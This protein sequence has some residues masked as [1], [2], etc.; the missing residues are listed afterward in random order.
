MNCLDFE[1]LIALDVEGDLPEPQGRAVAEHL[2]ACHSCGQ[3]AESLKVSQALLKELGQEPLDEQ[4]LQEV[5]RRVR[6]GLANERQPQGFPAWR[7]AWGVGL[8]AALTFAALILHYHSRRTVTPVVAVRSAPANAAPPS[9]ARKD[10]KRNSKFETR[11]TESA[12]A[13]GHSSIRAG[14]GVRLAST[15]PAPPLVHATKGAQHMPSGK[16]SSGPL[17]VSAGTQHLQPLTVKLITDNP[18]VVIYW[19]VD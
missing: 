9:A 13:A 17:R 1:G 4:M 19:L 18:H 10:E 3:F 15:L 7:W 6:I 8:V 2:R 14:E 11:S 5:R 16:F 12:Q